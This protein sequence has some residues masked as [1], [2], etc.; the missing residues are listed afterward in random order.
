MC[1]ESRVPEAVPDGSCIYLEM[2]V[3]FSSG[4]FPRIYETSFRENIYL[5]MR[6]VLMT[7]VDVLGRKA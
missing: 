1:K 2:V 6:K 7:M 5:K 3:V 4:A